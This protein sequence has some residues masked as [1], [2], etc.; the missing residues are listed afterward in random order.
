MYICIFIYLCTG[1][2]YVTVYGDKKCSPSNLTMMVSLSSCITAFNCDDGGCV[3]LA[4][5]C[6]GISDCSDGS[7]EE[8]CT[9]LQPARD[10]VRLRIV[11]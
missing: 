2:N 9:T 4:Q 3:S 8:N 10:G 7:D 5:R 6:D 11:L 1:A